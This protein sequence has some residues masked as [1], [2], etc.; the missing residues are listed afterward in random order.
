M[1]NFLWENVK[2]Y[3][4]HIAALGQSMWRADNRIEMLLGGEAEW[5]WF[6]M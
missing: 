4:L 3:F 1:I 5:S 2:S 6:D